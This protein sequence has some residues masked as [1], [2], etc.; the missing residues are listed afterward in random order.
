MVSP[1][2]GLLAGP[3]RWLAKYNVLEISLLVQAVVFCS[4]TP[5]IG[6]SS[7][8]SL[9]Q[10]SYEANVF[11]GSSV[12]TFGESAHPST[13]TAP[14]ISFCSELH[15]FVQVI[16]EIVLQGSDGIFNPGF[17]LSGFGVRGPSFVY[18]FFV[19]GGLYR[20]L[21]GSRGLFTGCSVC[22]LMFV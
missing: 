2:S 10:F 1:L 20:L 19:A 13:S 22:S 9:L 8:S 14:L 6:F 21:S 18:V 15:I 16:L 12:S 4:L 3:S 11:C 17:L 7:L 5:I